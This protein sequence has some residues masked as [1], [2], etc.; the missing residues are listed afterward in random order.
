VNVNFVLLIIVS[1]FFNSFLKAQTP[2]EKIKIEEILVLGKKIDDDQLKILAGLLRLSEEE[3]AAA[4]VQ[5]IRD[6]ADLAANIQIIGSSSSRYITPYVRGLGNQDL[7]L[8]DDISVNFYLDEVPLPRFA[9]ETELVDL[10]K[11][12]V[13]RGP[14]GTLFGK[15]TL[16]GAVLLTSNE[17]SLDDRQKLNL[18]VG[19][20]GLKEVGGTANYQ[21]F[22]EDF[23][24]R[25]SFKLKERD[26]WIKDTV[27]GKDLG[28]VTTQAIHQ[29]FVYSPSEKRKVSI[30]LGLQREDGSDP[31][32]ISRNEPNFPVSG[33]DLSPDYRRN[34]SMNSVKWEESFGEHLLTFISA[35][36][37]YDF[38]VKYDEA[39]YYIARD[40]LV[41]RVGTVFA[42]MLINDPAV[43]YRQVDEYDRQFFNEVRFQGRVN[44]RLT[45]T[46]GL[47]FS[48]TNYRL[49]NF[50][51]TY[52]PGPT[53][54]GQNIQLIGSNLSLFA[55]AVQRLGTKWSLS[56][57]LRGNYD[58]KEFISEHRS[59][60]LAFYA[61]ES[62]KT[63]SDLTGKLAL[64]YDWNTRSMSFLSLARGYQPGGYPSFQFNNY[65]SIAAD[66][67]S[68]NKSSSWAYEVGHKG[69]YFDGLLQLNS[70]LYYNQIKDKQVRVRDP[71]TNLSLYQ[72]IDSEIF[73]GEIEPSLKI[74]ESWRWG[75]SLGYTNARFHESLRSGTS[76]VLQENHRLANIPY[77]NGGSFLQ[78]SMYIPLVSS[79]LTSRVAYSYTGERFGENTNLTKLPSYGLWKT[80]IALEGDSF[81]IAFI[82]DNIFDKTYDSQAYYY[83]SLDKE[84]SSPGLPRLTTMELS[85]RF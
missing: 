48:K 27:L 1:C 8:P 60:G 2:Q 68:F 71:Q 57:G 55:D 79:Y 38:T 31:F 9:F 63:F 23:L 39:D 52:S 30:K 82:V 80:R 21:I 42:D 47:N 10:E 25:T 43:L 65:S 32:F 37:Y 26:G 54:I 44:D 14:Q 62:E 58:K 22:S 29:S 72:N 11:I 41:N 36:N 51:N 35:F 53:T 16:A 50:V 66:Q 69:L 76:T 3:L 75:L 40:S 20:L 78:H 19:N 84:V 18:K 73:G 49:I 83:T 64:K 7:N 17:P 45:L 33:Q 5:T 70:G 28:D 34:L 74:G 81:G 4:G 12:E 6:V 15:N 59:T 13:L 67:D 24:A 85:Y 56:F 61:Q 46:T 77:W